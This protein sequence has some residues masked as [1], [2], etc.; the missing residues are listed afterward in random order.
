MFTLFIFNVFNSPNHTQYSSFWRISEE[1]HCLYI[2]EFWHL[3][4][5]LNFIVNE[6]YKAS[7]VVINESRIQYVN[8]AFMSTW[9]QIN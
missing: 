1:L 8:I 9:N 6:T 5:F 2:I 4:I 3:E 7:V